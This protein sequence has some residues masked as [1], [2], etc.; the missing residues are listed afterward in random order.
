MGSARSPR[1]VERRAV[2]N[3]LDSRSA[4]NTKLWFITGAVVLIAF[5]PPVDGAKKKPPRKVDSRKVQ[6]QRE[7]DRL[8]EIGQ[9]IALPEKAESLTDDMDKLDQQ[10]TLTDQQKK[11]ISLMVAA[12]DKTLAGWD[13][14]NRRKFDAMK[15]KFE[16]YSTPRDMRACKTIVTQMQSL[17]RARAIIATSNER[18]LFAVLTPDQRG[19]WNTPILSKLIMDEFASLELS[20]EQTAKIETAIAAQG[21]RLTV[22]LGSDPPPTLAAETVKKHI[23]TRILTAKQRKEYAAAKR[24]QKPG[25]RS[26]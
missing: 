17:S 15:V 25:Q 3:H 5:A 16:K 9:S 4:M 18:K 19:K 24:K 20:K 8:R 21:R 14:I 1:E 10:V 22:P 13:K 26:L 7:F 6:L 12:R 2:C 23:Y 11:K